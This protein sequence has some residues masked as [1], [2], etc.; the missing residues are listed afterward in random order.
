MYDRGDAW[1]GDSNRFVRLGRNVVAHVRGTRREVVAGKYKVKLTVSFESFA[2]RRV[3]AVVGV[4]G[5]LS[6]VSA[7]QASDTLP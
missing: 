4:S 5:K 6:V 3:R 7:F 2:I 1:D